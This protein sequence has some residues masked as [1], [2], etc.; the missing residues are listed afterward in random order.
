MTDEKQTIDVYCSECNFQVA[1]EVVYTHF[2]SEPQFGTVIIDPM[3]ALDTP[4]AVTEYTMSKCSK[5][6]EI[7]LTTAEF[8]ELPGQAYVPQSERTTLYPTTSRLDISVLPES[9]RKSY[10]SSTGA[11][12]AGLYGP[13]VI[14]CRKSVEG[15]CFENGAT[16]GNLKKRIDHLRSSGHI[17]AKLHTWATSLRLV[18]NDAAHDLE[19]E[20]TK[21]DASDSLEFL[22]ALL[23]Y[24]YVLDKKYSEF[25]ARR[26]SDNT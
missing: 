26:T 25:C 3:D 9:I 4:H 23:L 12:K 2:R 14:M 16:S 6:D 24:C 7:F 1:S 13:C 11:Y 18:G 8:Y 21:Q 20:I 15:L 22:D 10:V 19:V 5:C 17:D